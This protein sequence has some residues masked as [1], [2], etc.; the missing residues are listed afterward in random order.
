MQTYMSNP[1]KIERKW[2]VGDADGCTLVRLASGVAS[3]LRGKKCNKLLLYKYSS[4]QRPDSY[5]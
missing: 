1:E 3:V 5:L 4:Y 2:Y